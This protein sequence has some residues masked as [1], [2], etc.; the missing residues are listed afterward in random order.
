M[1]N[2]KVSII[3]PVYKVEAYLARCIDSVLRQTYHNLEIILVDDGSP[4]HCGEICDQYAEKDS[5]ISVYHKSNGGL[6][7]AR[8]YGTARATGDYIAY[9]DSD[10]YVA[11]NYI[12]YLVN[13]LEGH[14]ADISVC[15]M[16]E[17]ECDEADFSKIDGTEDE[18][19]LSGKDACACFRGNK[20]YE[21]V[22]SCGKLF[23][24]ELVSKYP[25]P[26]GR[27]HEDAATTEKQF[28]DAKVVAIGKGCVYAYYQ[29]ENSLSR[30]LEDKKQR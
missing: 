13:L 3:I 19:V 15:G 6:S 20:Y 18:L 26:V 17:T 12:E 21:F 28:Y 24:K 9:I 14:G 25:F 5:R 23:K 16:V 4:D 29:R 2:V 27:K 8:N 11:E 1:G 7:D 22:R 10:D 30:P